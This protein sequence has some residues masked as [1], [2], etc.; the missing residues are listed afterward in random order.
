MSRRRWVYVEG[1]G[2]LEVP[3]DYKP[4]PRAFNI[5][6]DTTE[7]FYSHA[8]GRHYTSKTVYRAELKARGYEEVACSVESRR[9]AA[10]EAS[11]PKL[12]ELTAGEIN[13]V[14]EQIGY[15]FG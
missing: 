10:I 14:A 2:L 7:P 11:K 3:A 12:P 4:Q 1:S 5:I 9:Q 13:Y 8:D 15:D 6:G